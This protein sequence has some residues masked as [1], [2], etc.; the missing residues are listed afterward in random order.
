MAY[1]EKI[2]I[3]NRGEIALRIL[4]ACHDLDIKAVVAYSDADR[5][6]LAV[7][8][9]DEAVCIGP[10]PAAKSYNHIPA[11]ISA[12]LA[13]G[14]DAI[15]PG[16][17]FLSE[18]A[19]IAEICRECNLTFIGPEPGTI[20]LMADKAEARQ[21]AM[22]AKIPVIPGTSTP[23]G[24]SV[25]IPRLTKDIGFPMMLKAVAGGGGRGMRIVND[26]RELLRLLPVAQAEAQSAFNNGGIYAER[27]LQRPRHIEVQVLG[28]RHGKVLAFGERDCSLQRRHQK[29]I[30][31]SPAPGISKKLRQNLER[32][33]LKLARAIR[34]S[35]AG[36]FEFLVD[37]DEKH[38]FIEANTR[39]QV[40]HPVTE[41]VTGIDLIAWQIRVAAGEHL[42]WDQDDIVFRGHAI[43]CRVN[44]ENA[45]ANFMPSTG[46]V[47]GYLAPG[48]P[49]IRV[50]SHL[51]SG[52]TVP[53]NYDSLIGK[54][55]A[56]GAT[57][58][59]AIARLR[60]A[61]SETVIGGIYTTIPFALRVLEHPT[62]K[63]GKVDTALVGEMVEEFARTPLQAWE[64]ALGT[65][66]QQGQAS[67]GAAGSETVETA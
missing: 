52:Y 26:E 66:Q 27:Y 56:W 9:A 6:S 17:G 33:A 41:A 62:F 34:Y 8:L 1:F 4:R 11:I 16:Y 28:D 35:G 59:E 19:Y 22:R 40:E 32:D 64:P 55:I 54:I 14:C 43:E 57:R 44:A 10:A 49:G 13:T 39:I 65:S 2:L 20:E 21:A 18:N 24:A 15:H 45:A 38:Y 5:E 37:A 36:T 48:G 23:L 58:E 12:A 51:Y 25:D 53:P 30:E 7:R 31:E 67:T 63:A 29:L 42:P 3:A 47:S 60:R 61:L 46:I 50:D